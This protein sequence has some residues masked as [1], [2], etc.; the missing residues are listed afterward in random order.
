MPTLKKGQSPDPLHLRT[1]AGWARDFGNMLKETYSG[2]TPPSSSSP[3]E[4]SGTRIPGMASGG[5][6]IRPGM[7]WVAEK[8]PE[9]LNMPRG[10]SVIPLPRVP[11]MGKSPDGNSN[12]PI[13]LVLPDGQVLAQVVNK[14]NDSAVAR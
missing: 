13:Y 7:A 12:R 4:H 2:A 9:L 3:G 6:V 10:A 14:S 1:F 8:G 11:D 5:Q